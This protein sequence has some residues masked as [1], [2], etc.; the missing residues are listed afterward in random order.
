MYSMCLRSRFASVLQYIF[1]QSFSPISLSK[2]VFKFNNKSSRRHP[3][4]RIRPEY[5]ISCSKRS[6]RSMK[7]TSVGKYIV[8]QRQPEHGAG[9]WTQLYSCADKTNI[10]CINNHILTNL[11]SIM[12][13]NI[14]RIRDEVFLSLTI[15][16]I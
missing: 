16:S 10:T 15:F 12:S 1:L 8:N 6:E 5:P 14:N 11:R 2:K 13:C 9:L 4:S 7:Q 3:F